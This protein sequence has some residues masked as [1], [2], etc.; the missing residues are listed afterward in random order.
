MYNKK[1]K[2]LD[3][4][5]KFRQAAGYF[6]YTMLDTKIFRNIKWLIEFWHFIWIF[7]SILS[8]ISNYFLESQLLYF[9]MGIFY[10]LLL[11]N[12]IIQS[13]I[14][15]CFSSSASSPYS[16]PTP[17][18]LYYSTGIPEMQE[19]SRQGLWG[20]SPLAAS[21]YRPCWLSESPTWL[22][23]LALDVPQPLTT[24][25]LT[26]CFHLKYQWFISNSI[27]SLTSVSKAPSPLICLMAHAFMMPTVKTIW[28]K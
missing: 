2:H 11:L 7:N 12:S 24:L 19:E 20:S 6:T 26:L 8:F 9:L 13:Q 25:A 16:D 23:N 4:K 10:T 21:S 27:S 22:S 17:P 18:S 14:K 5:W 3:E 28:W 15:H 1:W